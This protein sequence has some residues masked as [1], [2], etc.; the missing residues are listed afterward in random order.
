M[1]QYISPKMLVLGSIAD[2]T[3]ASVVKPILKCAGTGD[4]LSQTTRNAAG[5]NC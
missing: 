5:P 4:S 3:L 1:K 2:E